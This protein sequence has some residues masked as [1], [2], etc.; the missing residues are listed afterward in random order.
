MKKIFRSLLVIIGILAALLISFQSLEA[1]L[2]EPE[3]EIDIQDELNIDREQIVIEQPTE[4]NDLPLKDNPD[5]YLNDDPD[6]IVYMYVTVRRGNSGDDTDHTWQE[7]N[8]SSKFFVEGTINT[9]VNK[10]EAILQIGDENGPLPGQFGYGEIVP[11]A[12][13]QVRGNTSSLE[14]QKSYKIELFDSAGE[15][16]GQSTIALNKHQS[17][18]TRMRNKLGFELMENL[19]GLISLRTQYVNLFIK[20][21]TTSPPSDTFMDYGLFTQVELPNRK[22]LRNHL[23]DQDGQ[24]YKANMFEFFRYPDTLRLPDDPLYNRDLFE[25]VLEIKGNQDHSKLIQMLDDVNNLS[26]PIEQIFETYFDAENYF[27]WMAF[28]ILIGNLDTNSQNFYLYSP[29]NSQ[30]WYF[31]AWDYD[32]ILARQ[33]RQLL[34]RSNP[35]YFEKGISNY[36]GC[37]LHKRI[38]SKA[39]YREQLDK[40]INELMAY[41]APERIAEAIATYRIV[42]DQYIAK[43]PD[44]LYLPGTIDEY[45]TVLDILPDEIQINYQLYLDSLESPMPFFLGDPQIINNM[46]IFSWD[47]AYDFDAQNITYQLSISKNWNFREIVFQ[48]EVVNFLSVELNLLPPGEYFW[49]IIAVN[50]DGKMQY[51]FDYYTDLNGV[52]HPGIRNFYINQENQNITIT[53]GR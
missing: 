12:I 15:W 45:N 49:R 41:F 40:K 3:V 19:D 26:I 8:D 46:I 31:I 43:M 6:S 2:E 9:S 38:L 37:V 17:D 33:E 20:D 44:I 14:A 52:E 18:L 34:G 10:A 35:L 39:E 28:N 48:T 30:K 13:I 11:N 5:I 1:N 4:I 21:E 22:F 42:T 53:S 50:E 16:R 25:T 47:E 32:G 29:Q 36:W 27:I 23:L 7:V 51:P 24:L